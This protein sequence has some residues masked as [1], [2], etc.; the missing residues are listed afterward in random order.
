M[1][2]INLVT[3]T[4]IDLLRERLGQELEPTFS[5]LIGVFEKNRDLG[6]KAF[7]IS[8]TIKIA[9]SGWRSS[10]MLLMFFDVILKSKSSSRLKKLW[11]MSYSVVPFLI[12]LVA[13]STSRIAL[14][15]I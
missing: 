1:R 11:S 3:E 13:H 14:V 4:E 7:F 15:Y 5:R 12:T 6:S 2:E 9:E 10:E 8:A